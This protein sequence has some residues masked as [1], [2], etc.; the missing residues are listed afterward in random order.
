MHKFYL[1]LRWCDYS[2]HICTS[3]FILISIISCQ[4]FVWSTT[5]VHSNSSERIDCKSMYG[6]VQVYSLKIQ[7]L[8]IKTYFDNKIYINTVMECDA[9]LF[10]DR[11]VV[12]KTSGRNA[13]L[14][15]ENESLFRT[16]NSVTPG[17]SYTC[18]SNRYKKPVP[19]CRGEAY[20]LKAARL[21]DS[22][23]CSFSKRP[24]IHELFK[25]FEFHR[26]LHFFLTWKH[27]RFTYVLLL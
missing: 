14:Y 25:V 3:L 18:G 5:L 13:L 19:Y 11:N 8:E 17:Y 23:N 10:E 16:F 12:L 7:C 20:H 27:Y 4:S 15:C 9:T 2:R 22:H 26:M 21:S 24:K 6:T 1:I